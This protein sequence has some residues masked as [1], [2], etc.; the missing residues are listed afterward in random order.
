MNEPG[1]H[2]IPAKTAKN[3]QIYLYFGALTLFVYLA[4]PTGYLV[5]IA[6]SFMLK[7][8]LHADP[9]TV[10]RFRFITAIPV[11]AAFVF[12]FI[13]D[14]WN[15]L[16]L[17][18]RGY[19]LI[20]APVTAAI[21]IWLAFSKLTLSGLYVGVILTMVSFRFVMAGYQALI[22]L[23]GQEKL[24][25]GRLSTVWN[26]VQMLPV[27][28]AAWTSGYVTEHLSPKQ[29]F[30][31]L[32][33]LCLV[34]GALGL[35]KSRAVFAGAYEDPHARGSSLRNDVVRLFKHRAIYPAVLIM[36]LWNFAP[37]INTPLQ[38]YLT[39]EL[40]ASDAVFSNFLAIFSLAFI[41]TFLCFG[42]LCK[43][44]PLSKH[45][46]WGTL[47]AVPQLI[48][49]AF[50]HS[51][52]AAEIMA[53]PMGLM[54][55]VATAAYYDLAIRSCPPGLQGT[56]MMMVDGVYYLASRG[57][58][59][60]GTKIYG[61]SKQYGFLYCVI[62]TTVVYALILPVLLMIPK[63]LISTSDGEEN[64]EDMTD[65]LKEIAETS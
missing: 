8:Q 7:N 19:M 35:W 49:L 58:D 48:P 56:L 27:A 43:K 10:A 64:P 23:V 6:S 5:D 29:T 16:G 47:I 59:V 31:L 28:A 15:P 20:F 32:A 21:F 33:V 22:S 2:I 12:G 46:W 24:M 4:T 62:A 53:V 50:I 14:T 60:L 3:E 61:A 39:N 38:F 37:G 51:G 1:K 9:E 40:H 11:F 54:G 25:S 45:L 65:L 26:V 63:H 30:I 34:L 52:L 18:D 42:F 55:G 17:R 44:Y 36:F 57:G 13:R 41:P